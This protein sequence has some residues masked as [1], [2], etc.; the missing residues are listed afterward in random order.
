MC[1]CHLRMTGIRK[2][3]VPAAC[4]FRQSERKGSR[5]WAGLGRS[6]EARRRGQKFPL[7]SQEGCQRLEHLTLGTAD[8]LRCSLGFFVYPK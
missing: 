5:N 8:C 3:G 6:G 1:K 4:H 7:S 2:A